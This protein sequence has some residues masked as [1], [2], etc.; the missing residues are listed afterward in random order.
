M[1]PSNTLNAN[2]N[3]AP[4][5]NWDEEKFG[6]CG[7]LEVRVE[8]REGLVE[9]FSTWKPSAAELALLNAGGE[10]EVGLCAMQCAMR[11][12]VVPSVHFSA[13]DPI[14][15]EA[16]ASAVTI[17]EHAHGDDHGA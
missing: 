7:N 14:T 2:A 13:P 9:C 10:V 6:K 17:N 8:Q 11:V 16:R 4:P 12:G 3:F 5:V 15:H 1:I